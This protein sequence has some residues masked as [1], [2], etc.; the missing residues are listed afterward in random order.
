MEAQYIVGECCALW[1]ACVLQASWAVSFTYVCAP[2]WVTR[3]VDGCILS[4][5]RP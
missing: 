4:G 3:F 2:K 5:L 1:L